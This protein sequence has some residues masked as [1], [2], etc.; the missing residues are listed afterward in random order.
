M[1]K[2]FVI[3]ILL[4][5]LP[6]KAQIFLLNSR[7]EI[8]RKSPGC[9]SIVNGDGLLL[10]CSNSEGFYKFNQDGQ[11]ISLVYSLEFSAAAYLEMRKLNNSSFIYMG[12]KKCSCLSN[13]EDILYTNC[14]WWS[15]DYAIYTL[16]V[17]DFFGCVKSRI[18]MEAKIK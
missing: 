17:Y 16:G 11:C 7:E 2:L 18:T 6:S 10:K 3:I 9:T 15:G 14:E 5:Y 12:T 8:I 4:S 13:N 1:K